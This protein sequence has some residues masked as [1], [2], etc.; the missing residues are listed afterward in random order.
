MSSYIYT[1]YNHYN[2]AQRIIAAVYGLRPCAQGD[3]IPGTSY[4]TS[5]TSYHGNLYNNV[6][7]EPP[8]PAITPNNY[9]AFAN[10][11]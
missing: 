6:N 1:P 11:I 3:N 9:G 4:G 7:Y 5:Y 10:K 8:P 2:D